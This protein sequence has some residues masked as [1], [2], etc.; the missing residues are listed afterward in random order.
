MEGEEEASDDPR[1]FNNQSVWHRLLILV[2][3]AAMNFLL[4]LVLVIILYAG[5]GGFNSPVIAGFARRL[6]V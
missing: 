6:P 1:A 3:G 4:G 5:A 2:A